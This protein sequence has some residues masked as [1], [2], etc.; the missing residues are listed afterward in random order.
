MGSAA[1]KMY[2]KHQI[3]L[4]IET[5]VNNVSFFT[6]LR[7]VQ[8]RDGTTETKIAPVKKTIYSLRAMRELMAAAN[9]RYLDFISEL[10]DPSAGIP[11]VTKLSSIV[12]KDGRTYRGFNVFHAEDRDLFVALSRGEFNVTGFKNSM[13]RRILPDRTSQQVSRI[14]RRLH[15]HGLIKKVRGRYKYYLSS[16]GRQVILTALKLRELVVIPSMAPLHTR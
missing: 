10:D 15:L 16:F 5:T 3:V 1:I 12:R 6:H 13:L 4:R 14:L 7:E 2:D 8:H 9:R 11:K